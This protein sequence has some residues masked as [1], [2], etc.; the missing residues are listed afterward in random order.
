MPFVTSNVLAPSSTAQEPLVA[1]LFLNESQ[2]FVVFES[3]FTSSIRF[4]IRVCETESEAFQV[5]RHSNH[6]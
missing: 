6:V 2:R 3:L 5:V 4:L 1:F